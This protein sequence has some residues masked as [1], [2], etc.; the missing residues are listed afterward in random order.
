MAGERRE[1]VA[2]TLK[3]E[4]DGSQECGVSVQEGPKEE[5]NALYIPAHALYYLSAYSR[6]RGCK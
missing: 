4:E 2:P 5:A 3:R 1:V 6:I